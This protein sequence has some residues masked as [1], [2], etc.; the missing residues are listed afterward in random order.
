[1]MFNRVTLFKADDLILD[2]PKLR[3]DFEVT[4]SLVGYPNLAHFNIYN[5]SEQHRNMLISGDNGIGSSTFSSGKGSMINFYAGYAEGSKLLFVGRVVNVIHKYIAPDWISE[6]YAG[7]AFDVLNTATINK[8]LAPGAS[9]EQIFDELIGEM[10]GVTKGIANGVKNCLNRNRSTIRSI[11]LAG[12]VKTWLK[13]LAE[14]CG[15]EWSINDGIIETVER[16]KPLTDEEPFVVNQ[17]SGMIGSPMRTDVGVDVRVLLRPELRLAR[18]FRVESINDFVNVGN[19]YYRKIP[20]IRNEG[21]YRIDRLVHKGS[22]RTDLWE[23]M[24]G[25]RIYG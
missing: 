22:T 15:F 6:I 12:D 21:V 4:K 16:G 13:Q 9:A 2:D 25:G 5:L 24:I 1:M 14:D 23:T 10:K 8:T 7:D 17:D 19:L 20:P 18:R 11:M 3:I